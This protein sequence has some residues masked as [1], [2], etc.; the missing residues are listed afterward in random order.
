MQN[1]NAFL[2]SIHRDFNLTDD[3]TF[4][5]ADLT[6]MSD[7]GRVRANF[8]VLHQSTDTAAVVV[9]ETVSIQQFLGTLSHCLLL[10]EANQIVSLDM[11]ILL[12]YRNYR[13]TVGKQT[14]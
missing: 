8:D 13:P 6:D 12:F 2:M 9:H 11:L 10:I 1:I 7:F 5:Y 14:I 3:H 4:E